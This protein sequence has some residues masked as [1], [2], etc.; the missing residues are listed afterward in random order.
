MIYCFVEG[1]CEK[2]FIE[3]LLSSRQIKILL[4]VK[5]IN[6]WMENSIKKHIITIKKDD[7]IFIIFDTDTVNNQNKSKFIKNLNL[8]IR[9]KNKIVLLEQNQNFE[10]ELCYSLNF[11]RLQLLKEFKADGVSEFKSRFIA[12]TSTSNKLKCLNINWEKLWNRSVIYKDI[13]HQIN[14][15]GVSVG[16]YSDISK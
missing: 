8:L 12:L 10:D 7:K 16:N 14:N 13:E 11:T 2:K 4:K 3:D 5:K 15:K 6:L 9:N 1:E